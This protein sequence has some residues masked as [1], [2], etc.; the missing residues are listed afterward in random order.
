VASTGTC[1][2]ILLVIRA[3]SLVAKELLVLL[4]EQVTLESLPSRKE[5]PRS[6]RLG[7]IVVLF[8]IPFHQE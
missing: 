7:D 8:G 4:L 2:R 1:T 6:R 3:V 5:T